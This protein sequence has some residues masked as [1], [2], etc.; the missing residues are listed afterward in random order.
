MLRK[1]ERYG[2]APPSIYSLAILAAIR[3]ASSH[4]SSLAR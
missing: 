4:M 1:S 3:H 2:S